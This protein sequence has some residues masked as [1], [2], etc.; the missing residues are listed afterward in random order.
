[1]VLNLQVHLEFKQS[2]LKCLVIDLKE[3]FYFNF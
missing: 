1:M 3:I 2:R